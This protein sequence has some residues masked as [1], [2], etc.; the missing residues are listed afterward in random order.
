MIYF[1][2]VLASLTDANVSNDNVAF[3]L[4]LYK[5]QVAY[6]DIDVVRSRLIRI[7]R[8]VR[9]GDPMSPALFNNATRIVFRELKEKW[10][11]E[12]KGTMICGDGVVKSTHCMFADDT[13]LLASSRD[14]LIEMIKDVRS[15]LAQHGLNLNLDKCLAQATSG[16][17]QPLI[18]EGAQIPMVS[19]SEGFKVLG[20]QFTLLGRSST[21]LKCRIAAA[22]AKFHTLWP[23]L[24]KRDGN[25]GKRLRLF[26]TCVGQTVLWCSESRVLTKSEKRLLQSTQR[27]MLRRIAGP[28]RRPEEDWVQW[29]RRST[30]AALKEAREANVRLWLET[31]LRSKW[32]WAGHVLRMSADRIARRAATWRDSQWQRAEEQI[33]VRF[34]TRR[35]FRTRWFRWEDELCRFAQ[36][37]CALAW[38]DVVQDRDEWQSWTSEFVKFTK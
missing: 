9:Q 32:S 34:R 24:G 14:S 12:G 6:V 29:V 5:C 15:A 19:A 16:D 18:V 28:R 30:R 37:R 38:Q 8:G 25:L 22:W 17:T 7:L 23:L 3:L 27:K 4:K 10:R 11:A 13:T 1:E 33:P 35:P 31:H 2:S 21:D 36:D 26:D 20:T